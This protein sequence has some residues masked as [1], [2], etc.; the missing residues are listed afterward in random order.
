MHL[1]M[2]RLLILFLL[3]FVSGCVSG[4]RD[5]LNVVMNLTEEEWKVFR[6]DVFPRFE[7]RYGIKIKSYQIPS[8]KLATKLE[9][10]I[11]AG[12]SEIDVFAQDNM[13]L[14]ALVN[15]GLIQ[16]L[17]AYESKIPEA[18]VPSLCRSIKLEDKLFFMP[19]RPNVQITYI[20]KEAFDRYQLPVPAT[21]DKLLEAAKT[22]KENEGIGRVVIKGYGGNPTATQIYEFILQA[23]GDPY[24]FD[25][26]GCIRAF[27]FLQKLK[28][29][30]SPE[31]QRA[32]WD[33]VNDI[34]GKGE[35]YIGQNWPFGVLILIKDYG[36]DFI[37]TYSG[38]AGPAGEYHVVG[39]DVLGI[40]SN[41][42]FKEKALDFIFFLQSREVQ[43][44]LV[45]ELGWPSIREDA[46]A[47]VADW[48]KP[49]FES[50]KRA[51]RKGVF[52][53]NVAWWPAYKKYVSRAFQ[54]IVMEGKQ[55]IPT[56]RHFKKKLEEE[57]AL[58]K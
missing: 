52:R 27:K 42:K 5:T 29:Y 2:R 15:K 22:F 7:S 35:A 57:K 51:L 19:F 25:D 38:W 33:T 48:Q 20:N 13:S 21:W 11:H 26:E 30:L 1:A 43:E 10:L 12:K 31:S 14:A 46:Y 8:G 4:E 6:E 44:I 47:Q 58:Y 24:A 54:D 3:V 36:L 16:E 40:P 17:S 32:K 55:V 56:L 53:K 37:E 18:V 45:K 23:G 50:V 39:G 28:P 49:H 41:A 34:L 9:A